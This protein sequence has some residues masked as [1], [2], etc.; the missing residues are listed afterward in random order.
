MR[1]YLTTIFALF[2]MTALANTQVQ[3]AIVKS[4]GRIS[5]EGKIVPGTS[6]SGTFVTIRGGNT[7]ESNAQGRLSFPVDKDAPFYLQKVEKTGYILSDYDILARSL[8]HSASTPLYIVLEKQGDKIAD[9]LAAAQKI[10]RTLNS[11]LFTRK[12]ELDALLAANKI[13]E[14][15]YRTQ[16]QRLIANQQSAEAMVKSMS[17]E[18]AKIDFDRIDDFYREISSLILDGKLE[19]A[20]S[21]LATKGDVNKDVNQLNEHRKANA[22]F[23]RQL[24]KRDS[25]AHRQMVDIADRCYKKSQI[26]QLRFEH[27]SVVYYLSLRADLDT[28]NIE[29]QKAVASHISRYQSDYD[30]AISIY[31]KALM[32]SLAINGKNHQ[33]TGVLYNDIGVAYRS[34]GDSKKALEYQLLA[35]EIL[36]PLAD[37]EFIGGIYSNLLVTYMNLSDYENVK[38]YIQLTLAN[39]PQRPVYAPSVCRLSAA[40]GLEW[41]K[42]NESML[43]AE[44]ILTEGLEFCYRELGEN[45][46]LTA[47]CLESLASMYCQRD[48]LSLSERATDLMTKALNIKKKIYGEQHIAIAESILMQSQL[49]IATG[50]SAQALG[51]CKEALAIMESIGMVEHNVTASILGCSA[52]F[53]K[54]L[55]DLESAEKDAL[56]ALGILKKLYGEVH[57][58]MVPMYLELSSICVKKGDKA[59]AIGY[60]EKSLDIRKAIYGENNHKTAKG[61]L[62]LGNIYKDMGNSKKALFYY[63]NAA[64]I[65]EQGHKSIDS[66]MIYDNIAMLCYNAKRYKE[67]IEN[68]LKADNEVIAYNGANSTYRGSIQLG[69]ASAYA[70][71]GDYSKALEH[72]TLAYNIFKKN[73]PEENQAVAAA[74]EMVILLTNVLKQIKQ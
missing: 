18:F 49:Y 12:R 29:W 41:L 28:L 56:R 23:R 63:S 67:A 22:L 65:T 32:I 2:T 7:W 9:E 19:K 58:H 42:D 40:K 35:K 55:N 25:V 37:Y 13:A 14:E 31:N 70:E 8:R 61:Y 34:A 68:Y 10:R 33:E 64:Q 69:L 11:R 5:A 47:N 72:A 17:E 36:E 74:K 24:E 30:R 26:H 16:L 45:N 6:L 62:D 1:R 44:Q 54:K 43:Q 21:L 15:E 71:L 20:D 50:N 51:C 39:I 60:A 57:D 4:K 48:I 66:Y 53:H 38:K 3:Q 59:N 46:I 52:I 27:D 73:L